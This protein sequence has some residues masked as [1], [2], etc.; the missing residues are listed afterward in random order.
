MRFRRLKKIASLDEV[1]E[2]LRNFTV[3]AELASLPTA[4]KNPVV[5]PMKKIALQ[6]P[7]RCQ[8]RQRHGRRRRPR[9]R[10]SA[11]RRQA[12]AALAQFG[13]RA[14]GAALLNAELLAARGS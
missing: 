3:D 6:P 4:L 7:P 1:R 9:P 14:A 2:A 12:H 10:M 8:R 5:V 11:P 13:P